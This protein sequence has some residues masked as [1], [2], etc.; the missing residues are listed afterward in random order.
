MWCPLL[1]RGDQTG[2]VA[3]DIRPVGEDEF[4]ASVDVFLTALVLGQPARQENESRL[5]SFEADRTIAAFVDDRIVGTAG[6]HTFETTVP[7]GARVPTAG[8]TRVGVL[9][10]HTRR[11]ILRALMAE[12]L[13]DVRRRGEP[14]ASL[15][16]S[17]SSI[18]RRFGYG[19]AGLAADYVIDTRDAAFGVEP[20]DTGSLR[21]VDATEV[22]TEIP[23]AYER[24]GR[25]RAGALGRPGWWWQRT[26]ADLV[27]ETGR[28]PR[29]CVVHTDAAGVVDGF[30]DYGAVDRDHWNDNEQ[31]LEVYALFA[32]GPDAYAALWRHVLR[33][34]LAGRVRALIRPVD[35]PLRW[36]LADPRCLETTALFDEQWVRLV[37]VETALSARHYGPGDAVVVHVDDAV[38]PANTGTY[39]VSPDGA[40]RTDDRPDLRLDVAALGAVY[41]GGT[42]FTELAAAR[43]VETTEPATLAMADALFAVRPQ[44]WCGTHF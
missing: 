33:L 19:V 29:W 44:P 27:S 41:L 23:A 40:K 42:T 12:Q 14:L 18:Y 16:A 25:L 22:L 10:T 35:E 38:L 39:T 2:L 31:L 43:L 34:D 32:D 37:D 21:F 9:P 20:S 11:G 5:G 15:R 13:A 36:L 7:G 17:E 26:L 8:V 3:I 1:L 4:L 6:A 28:P 24:V 30:V